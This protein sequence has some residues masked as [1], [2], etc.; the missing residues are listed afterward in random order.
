M[1]KC[2][3]NTCKNLKSIID[4]TDS[5]K[6]DIIEE[7]EFGFP[8][9]SCSECEEENCELSCE[10]YIEDCEEEA[11]SISQCAACGKELKGIASN[12]ETGEVYCPA[13]YLEKLF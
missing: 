2:I 1:S 9:E 10:H 5:D 11:L 13:C 4:E 8:S 3:C 6:S 7:C 12:M